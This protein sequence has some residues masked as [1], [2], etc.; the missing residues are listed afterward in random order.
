MHNKLDAE[1]EYM[2]NPLSMQGFRNSVKWYLKSERL[3]LKMHYCSGDIA[4]PMHV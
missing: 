1:F 4:N 2:E 3:R